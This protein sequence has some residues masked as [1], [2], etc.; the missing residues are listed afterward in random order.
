MNNYCDE[1]RMMYIHSVKCSKFGPYP[2][3]QQ[4]FDLSRVRTRIKFVV[5]G[6][7]PKPN[8]MVMEPYTTYQATDA[9]RMAQ[10]FRNQGCQVQIHESQEVF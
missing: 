9:M 2:T 6:E 10:A 5:T 8:G 4:A 1:C 3:M 7:A